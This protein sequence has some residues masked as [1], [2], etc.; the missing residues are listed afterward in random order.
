MNLSEDKI[1]AYKKFGNKIWNAS[2]F[3]MESISDENGQIP[4]FKS[5]N[6]HQEDQKIIDEYFEFKKEK[7]IE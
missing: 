5:F 2:R 4:D 6:L 7:T 3:V 1:R